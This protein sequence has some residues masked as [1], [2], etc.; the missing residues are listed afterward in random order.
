MTL[1][2]SFNYASVTRNKSEEPKRLRGD[3]DQS[4]PSRSISKWVL[5]AKS[6]TKRSATL[7]WKHKCKPYWDEGIVSNTWITLRT[8]RGWDCQRWLLLEVTVTITRLQAVRRVWHGKVFC[9]YYV[10]KQRELIRLEETLTVGTE[11][12]E[13]AAQPRS[14]ERARLLSREHSRPRLVHT[15]AWIKD[16]LFGHEDRLIDAPKNSHHARTQH[17]NHVRVYA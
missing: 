6:W 1:I 15:T 2:A 12:V 16:Q 8:G 14:N 5:I 9:R 11:I 4:R 7:D 10:E 3:T 13:W 17:R